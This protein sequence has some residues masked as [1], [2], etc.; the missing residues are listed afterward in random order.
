MQAAELKLR[1]HL[2]KCNLLCFGVR[3]QHIMVHGWGV[4]IDA[5][6]FEEA[7]SVAKDISDTL[8]GQIPAN[9]FLL[10]RAV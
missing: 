3:I 9:S 6:S 4:A 10:L 2:N 7:Q 1:R 5:N 8:S